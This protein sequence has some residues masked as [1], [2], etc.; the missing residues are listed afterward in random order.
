MIESVFRDFLLSSLA[1]SG[2]VDTRVYQ[3]RAPQ[4]ATYPLLVIRKQDVDPTDDHGYLSQH[5]E[6]TWRIMGAT[7]N[8]PDLLV[9]REALRG[10]AG[11][12]LAEASMSGRNLSFNTA[13]TSIQ[14][15]MQGFE[16][17]QFEEESQ[18]FTVIVD[19][20]VMH[21]ETVTPG[22]IP[23]PKPVIANLFLELDS[24]PVQESPIV[25]W[26][27]TSGTGLDATGVNSPTW[28]KT[29]KNRKLGSVFMDNRAGE[30]EHFTV[31][32]S[33]LIGTD[34]TIFLAFFS[35]TMRQADDPATAGPQ[36][37]GGDGS[38]NR[39]RLSLSATAVDHPTLPGSVSFNYFDLSGDD[40]DTRTG[41]NVVSEGVVA[42]ITCRA[43][44]AT[45]RIV[46]VNGVQEGSDIGTGFLLEYPNPTIGASAG[47]FGTKNVGWLSIHDAAVSDADILLFEAWLLQEFGT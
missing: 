40:H 32:L 11:F 10:L 46:R 28:A 1:L 31:D 27:G 18:L 8:F 24:R 5:V 45:G 41:N 16:S 47:F 26:E 14:S 42:R 4:N 15:V 17:D 7:R 21:T 44:A 6:T 35:D 23:L 3:N 29:W 39:G 37:I 30:N 12:S 22:I 38:N 36:F 25:T 43:S 33:G 9:L 20:A 2:L 13:T 19:F 34:L